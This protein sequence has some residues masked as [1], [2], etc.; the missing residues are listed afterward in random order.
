M[1]PRLSPTLLLLI[2]IAAGC[3]TAGCVG[4]GLGS[5]RPLTPDDYVGTYT[6]A[7]HVT[8]EGHCDPPPEFDPEAQDASSAPAPPLRIEVSKRTPDDPDAPPQL[9]YSVCEAQ[10]PCAPAEEFVAHTLRWDAEAQVATAAF[11]Q[12]SQEPDPLS[13][14]CRLERY[15]ARLE[16]RAAGAP[17]RITHRTW[18][19]TALL[20][21]DAPCAPETVEARR[22]LLECVQL[23]EYVA[24]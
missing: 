7:R 15:E 16:R 13:N 5:D 20:E 4:C 6:V 2:V 9:A 21:G 14:R 1:L 8:V 23:E 22:D 17:I 3:R 18:R 12:A 24:R 19:A 10:G 11:V